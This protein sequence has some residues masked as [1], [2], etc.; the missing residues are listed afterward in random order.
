MD[1]GLDPD[2]ASQLECGKCSVQLQLLRNC[3]GKGTPAK[4]ELNNNFYTRC[5]RA[6]FLESYLARYLTDLYAEC[7]ENKILPAPG[8][9]SDQTQ[10]TK[11]LF[12]FLDNIVTKYR[13]Q[14]N[15]KMRA[16]QKK[17]S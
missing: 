12:D 13:N 2:K 3:D 14:M 8:S 1:L 9:P 16:E 7:R 4:I 11:E 6:I 17:N 10:F 5:P 15:K